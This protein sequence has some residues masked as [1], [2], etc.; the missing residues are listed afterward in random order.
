MNLNHNINLNTSNLQKA[1]AEE[2]LLP[3]QQIPQ[4]VFATTKNV[5]P[6]HSHSEGQINE[7]ISSLLSGSNT[8]HNDMDLRIHISGRM[9]HYISAQGFKV[10]QSYEST[11]DSIMKA[12]NDIVVDKKRLNGNCQI[13][14]EN[15]PNWVNYTYEGQKMMPH[16]NILYRRYPETDG[17]LYRYHKLTYDNTHTY[18]GIINSLY[19]NAFR[20]Y[21][22]GFIIDK[23]LDIEEER[24]QIYIKTNLI[25]KEI[26][27]LLMNS[28]RIINRINYN[29]KVTI[30][31]TDKSKNFCISVYHCY[32]VF[33]YKNNNQE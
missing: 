3:F 31:E 18:E 10:Y 15:A 16:D 4:N 20:V 29:V 7:T 17:L 33:N 9:F 12:Y 25:S 13:L 21:N 6:I 23:N 2:L 1:V 8:M 28:Y 26:S 5:I 30:H 19:N 14:F 11:L 27:D 22:T 32:F 24:K